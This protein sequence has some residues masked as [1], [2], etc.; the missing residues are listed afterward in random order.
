MDRRTF[1]IQYDI[2]SYYTIFLILYSTYIKI[3]ILYILSI[4]QNTIK[5]DTSKK[6]QSLK[7][8]I[9]KP[10]YMTKSKEIKRVVNR[11][12]HFYFQI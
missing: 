1:C 11:S 5:F 8:I 3:K 10:F 6:M 4:S 9:T 7:L 2:R 12:D